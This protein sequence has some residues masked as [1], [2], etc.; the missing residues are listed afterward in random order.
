MEYFHSIVL[1]RVCLIIQNHMKIGICI[2]EISQ[3]DAKSTL[4]VSSKISSYAFESSFSHSEK[5]RHTYQTV[6][7]NSDLKSHFFSC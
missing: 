1:W 4:Y 7:L 3:I 5:N 2:V 6:P